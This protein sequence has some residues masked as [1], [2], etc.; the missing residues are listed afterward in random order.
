MNGTAFVSPKRGSA[1]PTAM[2]FIVFGVNLRLLLR[3]PLSNT[4]PRHLPP[5]PKYIVKAA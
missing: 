4:Q 5:L 2:A 3:T 1:R